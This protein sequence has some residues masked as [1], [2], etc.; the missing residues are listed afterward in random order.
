MLDTS[1]LVTKYA[2]F[3]TFR[4]VADVTSTG[5]LSALVVTPQGTL[6][7]IGVFKSNGQTR[8]TTNDVIANLQYDFTFVDSL[9]SGTGGFVLR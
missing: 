5:N 1:P 8:A 4:F 6:A 9:S 7:T 2:D 3:D